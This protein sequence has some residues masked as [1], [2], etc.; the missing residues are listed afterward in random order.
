[1]FVISEK[2]LNHKE[3]IK[4]NYP[5]KHY[6]ASLAIRPDRIDYRLGNNVKNNPVI[7]RGS[8][9]NL[10][11]AIKQI[12]KNYPYC[13]CYIALPHDATFN[14]MLIL[15]DRMNARELKQLITYNAEN[16]FSHSIDSLQVDF[17]F[18]DKAKRQVRIIA[19]TKTAIDQI[20]QLFSNQKIII[21]L[22]SIDILAIELFLKQQLK[23]SAKTV[24]FFLLIAEE[25]IQLILSTGTVIFHHTVAI[26][27]DNTTKTIF[28]INQFLKKYETSQFNQGQVT[29]LI[30][31][32]PEELVHY[33]ET[34]WHSDI[35]TW[36]HLDLVP[37]MATDV[38]HLGLLYSC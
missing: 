36:L 6:K 5:F 29:E 38:I 1:M 13:S 4:V 24:A 30:L 17:E 10:R 20:K 25:L 31:L 28:E 11:E 2:S 16:Y 27:S 15:A 9:P 12:N 26:D 34:K 3:L 18:I 37:N 32:L 23:T 21:K 33:F 7:A 35:K 8:Y 22:I 19:T 14:K